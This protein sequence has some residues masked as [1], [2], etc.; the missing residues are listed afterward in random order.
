MVNE[1]RILNKIKHLQ[2]KILVVFFDAS[3]DALTVSV[4]DQD[5]DRIKDPDLSVRKR[6]HLVLGFGRK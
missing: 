2:N 4:M 3:P 6:Q 1:G 5:A